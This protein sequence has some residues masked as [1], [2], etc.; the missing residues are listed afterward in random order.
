MRRCLH[1]R[2]DFRPKRSDARY[3]SNLC[4]EAAHR[5]RKKD[6][7]AASAAA[8]TEQRK[9]AALRVIDQLDAHRLIAAMLHAQA[10]ADGIE[11][12]FMPAS[13]GVIAVEGRAGAFD[14]ADALI[15][16]FPYLS[17]EGAVSEDEARAIILSSKNI[18]GSVIAREAQ[19][20]C[21]E[22]VARG[23]NVY[24]LRANPDYVA[25]RNRAASLRNEGA[26][27]LGLPGFRCR[28]GKSQAG[29]DSWTC[30]GEPFDSTTPDEPR[31]F[32]HPRGFSLLR[33][34]RAS[35]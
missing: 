32:P 21:R 18:G 22:A 16:G 30:C 23:G 15:A 35:A 1:C 4:R 27:F 5:M 12:K 24:E 3:C 14:E 9:A 26:R 19:E 17:R 10:K 2:T 29:R 13:S 31:G 7:E 11:V 34:N 8:V 20:E 25:E 33:I 28:C 6:A